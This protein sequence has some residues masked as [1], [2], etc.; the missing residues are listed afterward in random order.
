MTCFYDIAGTK[1]H[2]LRH[3]RAIQKIGYEA[4]ILI[5]KKCIHGVKVKYIHGIKVFYVNERYKDEW[6][7]IAMTLSSDNF[8]SMTSEQIK[9]VAG[10]G[11][12]FSVR[13]AVV[14]FMT[15][16][17]AFVSLVWFIISCTGAFTL[18]DLMVFGCCFIV[19]GILS[20]CSL[21][22]FKLL[23]VFYN[24]KVKKDY[25][26]YNDVAVMYNVAGFRTYCKEA[27]GADGGI[28]EFYNNKFSEIAAKAK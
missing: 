4:L 17:I 18:R 26:G 23:H 2:E 15:I 27:H 13:Y 5:P 10:A 20:Y 1:C 11:L 12:F 7:N 9:K 14:Q 3:A 21:S 6:F 8:Q 22:I 19:L 28:Y 24:V 16:L 25:S